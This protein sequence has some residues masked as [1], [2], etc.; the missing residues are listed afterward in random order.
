MDEEVIRNKATFVE[1]I[2]VVG[3]LFLP[4]MA[5]PLPIAMVLP[6]LSWAAWP[7]AIMAGISSAIF[8]FLDLR[9]LDE[10]RL[11]R[12][13]KDRIAY[14]A[15]KDDVR[16]VRWDEITNVVYATK[17][18]AGEHGIGVGGYLIFKSP[19]GSFEVWK[20]H[21]F[22][23]FNGKMSFFSR[24]YFENSDG[25]TLIL[26]LLNLKLG[27]RFQTTIRKGLNQSKPKIL[28]KAA[29]L[30]RSWGDIALAEQAL[31]EGLYFV[32]ILDK[33]NFPAYLDEYAV[34]LREL[35]RITEAEEIEARSLERLKGLTQLKENVL[36]AL[37]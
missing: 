17:F 27:D 36:K 21:L 6:M 3:P 31:R 9:R 8:Y 19:K 4:I 28:R 25:A 13:S 10:E 29:Q 11:I 16:E 33:R 12:L 2:Q 7:I 26:T 20:R 32:P 18:R 15:F 24:G 5:L 14:Q 1:Y 23:F 34:I 30:L 37:T 22:S 35:G